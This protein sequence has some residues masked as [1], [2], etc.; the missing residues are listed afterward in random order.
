MLPVAND[1]DK[2]AQ[3]TPFAGL[4]K[5]AMKAPRRFARLKEQDAAKRARKHKTMEELALSTPSVAKGAPIAK[6][7]LQ[8]VEQQRRQEELEKVNLDDDELDRTTRPT[9]HDEEYREHARK[10]KP[11]GRH[12]KTSTKA[13]SL[14]SPPSTKGAL[15]GNEGG[16]YFERR[17]D[18]ELTMAWRYLSIL[19]CEK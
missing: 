13:G 3:A 10:G 6:R 15:S 2:G 12:K 19:T 1:V 9:V 17:I 16:A 8:K 14:L 4:R 5:E 7:R 18:I 11:K